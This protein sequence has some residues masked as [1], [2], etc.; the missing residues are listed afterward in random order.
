MEEISKINW[1]DIIIISYSR[2]SKFFYLSL[3]SVA[4]LLFMHYYFVYNGLYVDKMFAFTPILNLLYVLFDVTIVLLILLIITWGRIRLSIHL[5]FFI[6]LIWSLSNVLYSRFFHQCLTLSALGQ[7]SNIFDGLVFK[8]M[9]SG[10]EREDIFYFVS[11]FSYIAIWILGN[12]QHFH[13]PM[14]HKRRIFKLLLFIPLVVFTTATTTYFIYHFTSPRYRHHPEL[15]STGLYEN[16]IN[17]FI[18]K[19]SMPINALFISGSIRFLVSDMIE[20]LYCYDI[21]KEDKLIIKKVYTNHQFRK[22]THNTSQKIKN[23]IFI[24]LESFLATTSKLRVD[25]KEITP[26]LNKL[27]KDSSNYYNGNITPNITIGESGDGQLIYMTGLLPLKDKITVGIAKHRKLIG[28][29]HL[30]KTKFH[31]KYTEIIIPSSPIV[32]EQRY[33][34]EKYGIDNMLSAIDAEGASTF[35]TNEEKVFKLAESTK[36]ECKQPFFSMVLGISTHQPYDKPV[37]QTLQLKDKSISLQYK[38]YLS[39]C[40]YVDQQISHYFNYLKKH[41]IYDNSLIIIASDHHPHTDALNMQGKVSTFLP[42]YIINSGIC[43]K[44]MYQGI[45]NQL[46]VYTTILDILGIDNKWLGLGHT[47]LSPNYKNSVSDYTYDLSYKIIMGDY[48]NQKD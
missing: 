8:S 7:T 1:I 36:K 47:L 16:V 31:I 40:Y 13:L 28:L 20:E 15:L 33:M 45:A 23:V 12:K 19:H 2:Y 17:P 10:F 27:R 25:G 41:N 24:L 38:N 32:W 14:K 18:W 5:C 34:N 43:P 9:L 21:P 29:P 37:D 48:F 6:T 22:T 26:F 4:N 3:F 30:L 42:L 44:S 39:A 11:F 35:L 46:D